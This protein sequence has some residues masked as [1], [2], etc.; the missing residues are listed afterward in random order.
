MANGFIIAAPQSG[1]GKTTLTL[2]LLRA[3]TL[4]GEPV[5]S[6]K[7]GPDFIDPAFHAA[8]TGADCVN[9]DPW[10]MRPDLLQQLAAG[11]GVPLIVEAMMGLFDGGADG[12]GSAADL[13]VLLQLPVIL[14][15][16][17][18]KQ[19]HSIAALVAGFRDHRADI[20]IAG[21]VLNRVGSPRHEMMLREALDAINMPV[22]GCVGRHETLELP[23]RHLGLVQAREHGALDEFL[24]AAAG[25]MR[26][27]LDVEALMRLAK[28]EATGPIDVPE[29]PPLAPPGQRVAV[30]HDD[31]FAFVYPH[32]LDGWRRH[33]AEIHLFSPL[34]DETPDPAADAVYLPGGY[35]ELFAGRLA[36]NEKFLAGLRQ[37]ALNGAFVYG[38]CGG[39]MV[40]GE[41]LVDASGT[42]HPMADLLP[43]VTSFE[44]RKLHLG[45]RLARP[46]T[47]LP[48]ADDSV[49]LTAHEFHYSTIVKQE[50]EIPLFEAHDARGESLGA[51]GLRQGNVAGSYLHLIDRR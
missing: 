42:S 17:A 1:S 32:L 22:F 12:R 6:A 18:A 5:R 4:A 7:A 28:A 21:V 38:E 10:A 35:P 16:D 47:S 23:S 29:A 8:A 2:G 24:D 19:S 41:A 25:H 31:S 27:G 37:A 11:D 20:V 43:L 36:A 30:A 9:L 3:L 39:Y 49:V 46:T 48:F 44:H 40:L 13:A 51:C 33:G 14:V 34:A 45:Y 15:V 26:E 50:G